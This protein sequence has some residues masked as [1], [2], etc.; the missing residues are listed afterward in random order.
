MSAEEHYR[1]HGAKE[2]RPFCIKVPA[3]FDPT[4]YLALN[5]D[6]AQAGIDPLIHY[7][8]HGV[9]ENRRYQTT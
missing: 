4:L 8:L 7:T 3:D 9:Q 1:R 2:R 6:V 5:P